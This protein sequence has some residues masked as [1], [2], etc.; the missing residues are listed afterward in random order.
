MQRQASKGPA[1]DAEEDLDAESA[2]DAG[3]PAESHSLGIFTPGL[4][5]ARSRARGLAGHV[6]RSADVARHADVV[7]QDDRSL[8]A[9]R[10]A[11]ADPGRAQADAG[12]AR[13]RRDAKQGEG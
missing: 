4:R 7:L 9:E 11:H 6:V 2:T 5:V 13:V 3:S 1:H 12:I 8:R 10:V